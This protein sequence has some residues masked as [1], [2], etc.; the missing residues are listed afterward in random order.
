MK[1]KFNDKKAVWVYQIYF[2][3]AGIAREFRDY[4]N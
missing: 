1:G 2:W 3:Y 4:L